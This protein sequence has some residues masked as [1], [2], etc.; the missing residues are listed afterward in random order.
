MLFYFSGTGNS[1]YI[2]ECIGGILDEAPADIKPLL[3][4]QDTYKSETPFVF[5]TPTYAWRLPRLV[6]SWMQKQKFCGNANAY[7]V[8]TCGSEIGNA[9]KSLQ[10]LCAECGLQ[11]CGVYPV[12]MPENY[13]AMFSAPTVA[14]AQKILAAAAPAPAEAAAY[15]VQNKPFPQRRVTPLDRLYSGPVNP[16]FYRLFVKA[17]PFYATDACI[18]CGKCVQ[19]CPLGNIR[20]QAGKPVWG[21]TCTHCMACIAYCPKTAVEYGRKSAGKPRYTLEKAKKDEER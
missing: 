11:Y 8:M 20:L 4:T 5:V 19:A 2:A 21:D 3:Q 6:A 17:K 1:R 14:Q 15:I 9:Q 10:A 7:F 13:I 18:A 12:V 16:L